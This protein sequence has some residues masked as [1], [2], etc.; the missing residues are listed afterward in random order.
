[1]YEYEELYPVLLRFH[2]EVASLDRMEK[3]L[4]RI[5]QRLDVEE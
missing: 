4:D 1:M 3:P 5:E 2:R